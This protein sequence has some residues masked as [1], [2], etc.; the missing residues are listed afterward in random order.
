MEQV[1]RQPHHRPSVQ[2]WTSDAAIIQRCNGYHKSECQFCGN[3]VLP[4]LS[5]GLFT[6]DDF[7]KNLPG[8]IIDRTVCP[9]KMA[10]LLICEDLA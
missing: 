10:C 7:D 5:V 8:R 9:M 1:H 2:W 4:T 6:K 3:T